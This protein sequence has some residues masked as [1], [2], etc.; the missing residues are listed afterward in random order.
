MGELEGEF[1]G[2]GEE[3]FVVEVLA[4]DGDGDVEGVGCGAELGEV[5]ADAGADGCA[6][7]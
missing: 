1:D 4:A 5:D 7:L 6:E 3:A 2:E